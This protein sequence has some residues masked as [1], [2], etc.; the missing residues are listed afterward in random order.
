MFLE[1]NLVGE[2]VQ[3]SGRTF[4]KAREEAKMI[5]LERVSTKNH[6]GILSCHN[7]IHYS[8]IDNH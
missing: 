7:E 8:R 2:L 4:G 5:V 3:E 6:G 1:T